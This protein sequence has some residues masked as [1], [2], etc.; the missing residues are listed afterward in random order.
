MEPL[1]HWHF[2]EQGEG[3]EDDLRLNFKLQLSRDG[4]FVYQRVTEHV[5]G[6]ESIS[7]ASRNLKTPALYRAAGLLC[8][9]RP[10]IPDPGFTFIHSSLTSLKTNNPKENV[11][12]NVNLLAVLVNAK[13]AKKS[14]DKR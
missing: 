10:G 1:L 5:W 14:T 7:D 2:L 6:K 8:E 4:L 3:F 12:T 9:G 13:R 11:D